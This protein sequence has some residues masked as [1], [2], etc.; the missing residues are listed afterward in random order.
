MSSAGEVMNAVCT[1]GEWDA[2]CL[3]AAE[4]LQREEIS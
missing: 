4:E 2:Q 1:P 3:Q